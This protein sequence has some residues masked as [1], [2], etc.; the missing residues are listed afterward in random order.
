MCRKIV[1][2]IST[3]IVLLVLT[4]FTLKSYGKPIT[5]AEGYCSEN[6]LS[7]NIIRATEDIEGSDVDEKAMAKQMYRASESGIEAYDFLVEYTGNKST[8][9]AILNHAADL[10]KE[11]K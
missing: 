4:F 6:H 10:D 1:F 2:P 7:Y 5:S 8:A 9:E 3:V 11:M